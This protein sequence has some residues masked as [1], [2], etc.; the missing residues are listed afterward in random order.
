M[1][2]QEH[3]AFSD[4]L[5]GTENPGDDIALATDPGLLRPCNEDAVLAH[6]L[7]SGRS[8]IAVADGMG[9][10]SLGDVASWL[11]VNALAASLEEAMRADHA[12][13]SEELKKAVLRANEI[14]LKEALLTSSDMGTTLTGAILTPEDGAPLAVVANVGDS[15]AYLISPGSIRQ[16]TADHSVAA[17]LVS[18]GRIRPEE[19]KSHP[20][21]HV[22]YR[23]VGAEECTPD[24]FVEECAPE[25]LILLCTDGL[26][27][28]LEDTEIHDII[29]ASGSPGGACEGLIRAARERGGHDNISAIIA[30]MPSG[31]RER[32]VTP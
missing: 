2:T 28:E 9:G 29:I 5:A 7:P 25:D 10:H 13:A 16:I 26:W 6:P 23:S 24:I 17:K 31:D 11:A 19:L 32:E 22:L 15:R 30:R 20:Q 14:V 21:S 8:L 12:A 18:L 1:G 3:T 4:F 27:N